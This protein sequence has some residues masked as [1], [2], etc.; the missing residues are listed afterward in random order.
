MELI[1]TENMIRLLSLYIEFIIKFTVSQKKGMK[2]KIK[3]YQ[4]YL[5]VILL[6]R[7]CI[8]NG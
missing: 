1:L 4:D 5:E 7:K 3:K 6:K 8:N 2:I